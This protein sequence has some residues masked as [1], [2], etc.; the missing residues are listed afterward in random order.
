MIGIGHR[1]CVADVVVRV[2]LYDFPI[3]FPII[4]RLTIHEAVGW[5]IDVLLLGK[6]ELG[7]LLLAGH[8]RYGAH[9]NCLH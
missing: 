1:I 8:A 6:L 9:H 2:I 5:P 4:V 3:L 7:L